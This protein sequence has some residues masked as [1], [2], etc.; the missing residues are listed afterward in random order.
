[1]KRFK[2]IMDDGST[3]DCIAKSFREACLVFDAY[4]YDPRAIAA[5]EE[6]G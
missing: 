5:I 1:M 3:V 4:G 2:F 6:R